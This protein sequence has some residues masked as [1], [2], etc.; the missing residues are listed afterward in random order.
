MVEEGIGVEAEV[1][2]GL[3]G[4]G[5]AVDLAEA[6]LLGALTEG[7]EAAGRIDV[8]SMGE[9]AP[10]GVKDEFG[11]LLAA[12]LLRRLRRSGVVAPPR[13]VVTVLPSIDDC[14]VPLRSI[15]PTCSMAALERRIGRQTV[16]DKASGP[17][18]VLRI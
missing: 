3:G 1:A 5:W 11:I 16:L 9:V 10:N 2:P 6:P 15:R 14:Q 4:G 8:P 18:R 12:E 13:P 17:Q 7:D